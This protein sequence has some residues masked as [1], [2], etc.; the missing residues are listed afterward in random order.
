MRNLLTQ[1][2]TFIAGLNA[3]TDDIIT[4][5]ERLNALAGQVA[6]RDDTG[7]QAR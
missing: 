4:A 2:D 1:L 3:Q 6:A 5:T 7:R